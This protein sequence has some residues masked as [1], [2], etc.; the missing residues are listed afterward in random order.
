MSL[1]LQFDG[2]NDEVTFPDVLAGAATFTIN[3]D[4]N[5]KAAPLSFNNL[6]SNTN[7]GGGT[8]RNMIFTTNNRAMEVACVIGGVRRAFL[9]SNGIFNFNQRMMVQLQYDGTTLVLRIDGVV[10]GSIA[11]T[12]VLNTTSSVGDRGFTRLGL[13]LTGSYPNIDLYGLEFIGNGTVARFYN[14]SSSSGTSLVDTSVNAINGTILGGAS[15]VFYNSI[16]TTGIPNNTLGAALNQPCAIN[17]NNYF[18]GATSYSVLSGSL[19]AGLSISGNQ[20]VG[21]PTTA[22]STTLVIRAANSIDV[23]DSATITFNTGLWFLNNAS[24][25]NARISIPQV[26]IGNNVGD[27]VEVRSVA[28]AGNLSGNYRLLGVINNNLYQNLLDVTSTRVFVIASSIQMVFNTSYTQPAIG[29]IFTLRLTKTAASQW[30]ATLNG[31][32]IGTASTAA[33]LVVNGLFGLSNVANEGFLGGIYHV[34]ISTNGGVSSTRFYDGSASGGVGNL[35]IDRVSNQHGTQSG[36]W[37]AD[38]S[39]WVSYA[40]AGGTYTATINSSYAKHTASINANNDKPVRVVTVNSS[41]AKYTANLISTAV[42]LLRTVSI[43]ANYPNYSSSSQAANNKP[44]NSSNINSTYAKY[45]VSSNNTNTKPVKD[46]VITAGYSK[47]TSSVIATTVSNNRT[48]SVN[49]T[50]PKYTGI[51][52][53]ADFNVALVNSSYPKYTASINSNNIKPTLTTTVNSSYSKYTGSVVIANVD[54][55]KEI[56]VTA[57]Y[58]K[59]SAQVVGRAVGTKTLT[60]NA[61]YPKFIAQLNASITGNEET[62]SINSTYPKYIGTVVIGEFLSLPY[63]GGKGA[64]LTVSLGSRDVIMKD[65]SREIQWRIENARL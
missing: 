47:Y 33:A 63:I 22:Q 12:G 8:T 26:T 11:A 35:L 9:T 32:V 51:V 62:L 58:S 24:S 56:N 19:P 21:T 18:T 17:L 1:Y 50:Y 48:L 15:F 16:T 29:A 20:I 43:T 13:N 52:V 44:I 54:P 14:P 61:L 5:I 6:L 30:T 28:N 36:T 27:Y 59:Y 55:I 31:S 49:A 42:S 40:P 10:R 57:S 3:L 53:T 38:N 45:S 60:I 7:N 37:P 41:Y 23:L 65:Q 64:H 34:D 25:G 39:E 46:A 4:V 2:I